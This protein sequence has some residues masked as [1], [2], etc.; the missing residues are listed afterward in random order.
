MLILDDLQQWRRDT[1][2]NNLVWLESFG[3][4]IEWHRHAISVFHPSLPEY[5]ALLFYGDAE[6]LRGHL[7]SLGV[8]RQATD[9]LPRVYIDEGDE[10]AA[11][12]DILARMGFRRIATSVTYAGLVRPRQGKAEIQF[13]RAEAAESD[14]WS[15]TYSAG[16]GRTGEAAALDLCRWRLCFRSKDAVRSWFLLLN[17]AA[18]GVAQTCHAHNV[19]GVY[20][21]AILPAHRRE[22]GLR[23]I[24][25][26]VQS[27]RTFDEPVQSYFE[28]VRRSEH[29]TRASLV[30]CG[31]RF[32]VVRAMKVYAYTDSL[33]E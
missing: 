13:R 9:S 20:S 4:I 30:M 27:A 17:G 5:R 31:D 16:F 7:L 26:A 2:R 1:F 3:C 32:N 11:Y 21:V 18:I 24:V 28:V 33:H 19:V 8:G 10:S 14:L 29:P 25:K 22:L 15:A 6:D 12:N 23:T